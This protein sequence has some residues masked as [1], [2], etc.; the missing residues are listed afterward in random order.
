M[1]SKKFPLFFPLKVRL[2][3]SHDLSGSRVL[4]G[5]LIPK[6]CDTGSSLCAV[7]DC[8]KEDAGRVTKA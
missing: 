2:S 3:L 7:L 4:G 6:G 5:A 1:H 8:G